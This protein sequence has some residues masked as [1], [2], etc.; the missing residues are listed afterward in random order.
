MTPQSSSLAEAARR[1]LRTDGCT[2]EV[3]ARMRPEAERLA[4]AISDA[5]PSLLCEPVVLS[6]TES[7]TPWTCICIR[8]DEG[9]LARLG[10]DEPGLEA[11]WVPDASDLDFLWVRFTRL[12]NSL[13]EA[14]YPACEGCAGPEADAPWDERARREAFSTGS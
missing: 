1:L 12:V 8:A 9:L 5:L 6:D 11:C 7:A 2:L 10:G 3:P 14:G 4:L 13:L